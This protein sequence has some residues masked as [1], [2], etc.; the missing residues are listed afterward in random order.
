MYFRH[1]VYILDFYF[2]EDPPENH[3]TPPLKIIIC[4]C[5]YYDYYYDY[6]RDYYYDYYEHDYDYDYDY[7]YYYY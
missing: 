3:W 1:L 6:Y 2:S 7:D 5:N 4:Y